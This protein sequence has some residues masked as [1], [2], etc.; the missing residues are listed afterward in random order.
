MSSDNEK[1]NR[2]LYNRFK[3]FV[4]NTNKEYKDENFQYCH[5]YNELKNMHYE[6]WKFNF[7]EAYDNDAK[8][9]YLCLELKYENKNNV[10]INLY[11]YYSIISAG[12][13]TYLH[14]SENHEN[15]GETVINY[16]DN[17]VKDPNMNL[18]SKFELTDDILKMNFPELKDEKFPAPNGWFFHLFQ[19]DQ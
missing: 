16:L 5:K 6:R 10:L 15:L 8:Y 19:M 2:D 13:R 1:T 3:E 7:S 11:G 14:F 18:E 17:F 12:V 4:I 9:K